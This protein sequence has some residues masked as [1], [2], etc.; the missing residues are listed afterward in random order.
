[1][2]ARFALSVPKKGVSGFDPEER[3]EINRIENENR[4]SRGK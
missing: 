4:E 2:K 3:K 1:M